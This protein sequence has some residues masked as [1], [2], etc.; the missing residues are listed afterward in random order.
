MLPRLAA[1]AG[2]V[3]GLATAALVFGAIF[4]LAPEPTSP[5]SPTPASPA[6]TLNASLPAT[7]AASGPG[8]SPGS[9]PSTSP[10]AA[11]PSGAPEL[12]RAPEPSVVPPTAPTASDD[13]AR[14]FH[15]GEQAP[16][17]VVP[18]LG[19]G[20]IDL[21][22]LR[23]RP[24]WVYFWA[25]WCPSCGDEFPLMNGLAV[26][27]ADDGLVI[28]A[29]DVR[30]SED[31]VA[32]FANRYSLAFP[33]GLD[34]DGSAGAAWGAIALP[35]HYWVD[36]SGVIRAGATGGI[37]EDVMTESLAKVLPSVSPASAS[38]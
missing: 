36:A 26:R 15:I 13:A 5:A 3:A 37:G 7:P 21:A 17:L 31:M 33:V 9:G 30:E 20:T 6:P 8:P 22:A 11:S 28:L 18:Q 12:S 23:G 4:A 1:V 10:A 2:I 38:P 34:G 35:V 14:L 24:V 29:I 32:A 27:R 25:T 19:G 16:A